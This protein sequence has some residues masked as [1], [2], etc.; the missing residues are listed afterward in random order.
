MMNLGPL[1]ISFFRNYLANQKGYSP[2]TIAS[3]SDCIRLLLNYAC[4]C[5]GVSFDKLD[6]ERIGEQLILEFLDHLEQDRGNAPKTRNQRLGTI[7]TFFRFLALQEPMLTAVC[8]RVCVISAKKTEH[9]VI[10]T[11]DN[12]EVK[13]ILGVVNPET[14]Q[15]ARDQ[16]L[17]VML[18]NTGARVQELIDLDVSNLRMETPMQVLLTGKGRKQRIVPL[19]GETITAIQHYLKLREQAK[20]EED[21]LFLNSRGK[22]ITRFGIDY[23]VSKYAKSAAKKCPS[24]V[25]K[26]VTPHTY[27]HTTALHMIQSGIDIFVIKEW[28]GHADIKTTSLYVDIDIEM[29]RKALEACPSPTVPRTGVPE[30]LHW[31]D[32][33]VLNFLKGLSR[34]AALC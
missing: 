21:A 6:V 25:D 11:L 27:R 31:H 15:G 22:R 19:Y 24:L 29:K 3:Y 23:I 12:A 10:A 33:S 32:P 13:E 1:I 20:I 8:E 16:A 34:Q 26:D 5:I 4:E 2:N 18:Y 9:K 14:L 28:L 17:F 7:K 30:N